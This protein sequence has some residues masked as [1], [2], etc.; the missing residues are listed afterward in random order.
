MLRL[1]PLAAAAF[2]MISGAI[3]LHVEDNGLS[4]FALL[5]AGLMTLGAWIAVE[6]YWAI[7]TRRD[8]S[9]KQREENK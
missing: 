4:G 9:D 3:A 2:F 6:S 5:T 1:V 7:S 8:Q